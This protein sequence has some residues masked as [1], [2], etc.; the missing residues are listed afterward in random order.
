MK[1]TKKVKA[2]TSTIE[3]LASLRQEMQ[4]FKS[5]LFPRIKTI[6]DQTKKTNGSVRDNREFMKIVRERQDLCPARSY[7]ISG[8]TK[9]DYTILGVSL[10]S[11]IITGMV[12]I[13]VQILVT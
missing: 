4:D 7:F 6:E 12:I 1:K 2:V 8:T 5:E 11:S 13:I 9:K 3:A 10:V